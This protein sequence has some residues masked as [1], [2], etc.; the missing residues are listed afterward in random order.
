LQARV[1]QECHRIATRV[2]QYVVI[3]LR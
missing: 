3:V 1:L 2:L